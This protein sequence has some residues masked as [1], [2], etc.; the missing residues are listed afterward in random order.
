[1]SRRGKQEAVV[2][3][4]PGHNAIVYKDQGDL[5]KQRQE[6]YRESSQ[7]KQRWKNNKNSFWDEIF[8]TYSPLMD[9][10]TVDPAGAIWHLD[11]LL[12]FSNQAFDAEKAL[13]LF[14]CGYPGHPPPC[15]EIPQ[16]IQNHAK[17]DNRSIEDLPLDFNGALC[18]GKWGCRHSWCEY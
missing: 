9:F 5:P 3:I 15:N 16:F 18:G 11:H 4:S 10:A 1:M 17:S 8:E 7:W 14:D 2:N 13:P 6:A 12:E